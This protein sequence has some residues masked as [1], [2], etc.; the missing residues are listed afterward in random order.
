[1]VAAPTGAA[2]ARHR[3]RRAAAGAVGVSMLLALWVLSDSLFGPA[4]TPAAT[5]DAPVDV[6]VRVTGAPASAGSHAEL[7]AALARQQCPPRATDGATPSVA[8]L[9][10]PKTAG[11]P[12]SQARQGGQPA[13]AGYELARA[14]AL[15][16]QPAA[17]PDMQGRLAQH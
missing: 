14:A 13:H 3:R 11:A 12:R 8:F 9:H 5:G 1:M 15:A 6:S 17:R 7:E 2:Q 10:I 4:P 16:G